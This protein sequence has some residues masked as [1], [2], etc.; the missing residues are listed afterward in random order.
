MA[1]V[2][3]E[4]GFIKVVGRR[5]LEQAPEVDQLDHE[6]VH[7]IHTLSLSRRTCETRAEQS[8]A[9]QRALRKEGLRSAHPEHLCF[10]DEPLVVGDTLQGE[11]VIAGLGELSQL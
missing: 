11:D 6:C 7:L 10:G 8:R 2:P 4:N 9:E 1:D 3:R 5:R